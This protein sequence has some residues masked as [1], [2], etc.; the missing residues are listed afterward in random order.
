MQ[1]YI[2]RGFS[3][4]IT[5]RGIYEVRGRDCFMLHNVRTKF[6]GIDTDVRTTLRFCISNLRDCNARNTGRRDL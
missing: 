5:D 4:R 1:Q 6:R 2:L 3:V